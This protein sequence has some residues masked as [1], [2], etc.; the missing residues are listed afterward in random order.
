MRFDWIRSCRLP[1]PATSTTTVTWTLPISRFFWELGGR[2]PRVNAAQRI[3]TA[4]AMLIPLTWR[5]CSA[6]GVEA[7]LG[8]RA[9]RELQASTAFGCVAKL[10]RHRTTALAQPNLRVNEV[11]EK[12]RS[13]KGEG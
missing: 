9:E 1:F 4:T 12:N 10:T 3:S 11:R 13:V 5:C 2:A 6:T 8:W 7:T